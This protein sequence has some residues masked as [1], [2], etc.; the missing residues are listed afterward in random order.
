MSAADWECVC[1]SVGG[2][3]LRLSALV[4]ATQGTWGEKEGGERSGGKLRVG[5]EEVEDNWKIIPWGET[6]KP[7]V[8]FY[9][10]GLCATR[11]HTQTDTCGGTHIYRW[12]ASNKSLPNPDSSHVS[13]C[14]DPRAPL[15]RGYRH[16]TL[17]TVIQEKFVHFKNSHSRGFDFLG[18][19][20]SSWGASTALQLFF[21]FFPKSCVILLLVNF[22]GSAGWGSSAA[23]SKS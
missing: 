20:R 12:W 5:E 10:F 15:R 22:K 13:V 11:V 9:V 21:F 8:R 2:G 18:Y 17:S 16:N 7:G 14:K 3:L 19:C 1:V 4:S 23:Y 6:S